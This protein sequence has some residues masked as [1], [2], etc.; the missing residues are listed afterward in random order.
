MVVIESAN[1]DFLDAA[2]AFAGAR[3]DRPFI[4]VTPLV[5]TNGGTGYRNVPT[6][7]YSDS[8]W[9]SIQNT[10]GDA[11]TRLNNHIG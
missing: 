6:Y 9:D 8:V 5:V 11:F 4:L 3:H 1:R 10:G 2:S 7:H